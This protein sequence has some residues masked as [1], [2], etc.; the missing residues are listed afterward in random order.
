L[1]PKKGK[2][3]KKEEVSCLKVLCRAR[4]FSWSLNL[5][6]RGLRTRFLIKTNSLHHKKNLDL[7]PNPDSVNPDPKTLIINGIEQG[8]KP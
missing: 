2:E 3:R 4:G 8:L 5:L 1:F 7:D 6:S